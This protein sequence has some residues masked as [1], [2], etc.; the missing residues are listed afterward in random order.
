MNSGFADRR[1]RPLRHVAGSGVVS[2][3]DVRV[4]CPSR[5][6]TSANG[7]KVRCPTT[8]RRG[9]GAGSRSLCGGEWSGRRDSN[10]RPSP[11][12]G[13]ALPTEPLPLED[14]PAGVGA[15]S[16]IRTGDTAIFSRVLYQLSYLG[17]EPPGPREAPSA[18]RRIPWPPIERQ[19]DGP[20][21]PGAATR[22]RPPAARLR[23]GASAARPASVVA[24]IGPTCSRG[25][26]IAGYRPDLL[27]QRSIRRIRGAAAAGWLAGR[28]TSGENRCRARWEGRQGSD[29]DCTRWLAR[30]AS[31]I[32]RNRCRARWASRQAWDLTGWRASVV[33]TPAGGT[34]RAAGPAVRRAVRRAARAVAARSAMRTRAPGRSPGRR[35]AAGSRGRAA[36]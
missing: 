36:G 28:A 34:G 12:Q 14:V 13:D 31:D 5:I 1:V 20:L 30:W 17:P 18:R 16:Q 26:P 22:L 8:R 32:R 2:P 25:G 6:R 7:S 35:W 24:D 21:R 10:P 23:Q 27:A 11:W 33:P 15:E 19:G 4:G 9:S 29:H 3:V